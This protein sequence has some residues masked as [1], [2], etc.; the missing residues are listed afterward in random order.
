[1]LA[2][3]APQARRIEVLAPLRGPQSSPLPQL[4]RHCG[5]LRCLTLHHI[6][7]DALPA[8]GRLTALETLDATGERRSPS[9]VPPRTRP[10][11][12]DC[13]GSQG[14]APCRRIFLHQ[15]MSTL[16]ACSAAPRGRPLLAGLCRGPELPQ[17]SATD[18]CAAAAAARGGP[19]LPAAAA[20]QPGRAAARRLPAPD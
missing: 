3:L 11:A 17:G 19:G 13:K 1:M 14:T 20:R 6:H 7:A 2:S 18:G 10:F 9:A 12:R 16:P 8:V 5:R 15:H 4:E